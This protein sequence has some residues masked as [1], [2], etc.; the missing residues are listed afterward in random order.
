M[1]AE[2]ACLSLLGASKAAQ[3]NSHLAGTA[4]SQHT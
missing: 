2:M 4:Y 1:Q 3:I